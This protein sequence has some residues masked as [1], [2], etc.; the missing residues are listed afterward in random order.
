RQ[1][2]RI[3]GIDAAV[4]RPVGEAVAD[5]LPHQAVSVDDLVRHRADEVRLEVQPAQVIVPDRHATAFTLADPGSQCTAWL[6]ALQSRHWNRRYRRVLVC[7]NPRDWSRSLPHDGQTWP[8]S[9]AK[10]GRPRIQP[11]DRIRSNS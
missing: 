1:K 4:Q 11:P 6:H 2:V 3:P 8:P 7:W 5:S 9:M 10:L